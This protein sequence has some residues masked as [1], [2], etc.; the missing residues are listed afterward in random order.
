MT[1]AALDEIER[2]TD[3]LANCL[4]T[5]EHRCTGRL[6]AAPRSA[7]V[8]DGDPLVARSLEMMLTAESFQVA[9]A[10]RGAEGVKLASYGAF[11]LIVLGADLPDMSGLEAM[12]QLRS[13]GVTAV[14]V[15]ASVTP[16]TAASAAALHLSDCS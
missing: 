5:D 8:V 7:L 4:P 1:C 16:A 13:A 14:T 6:A 12:S 3:M 10:S 2:T 9:T 15:F 11:E